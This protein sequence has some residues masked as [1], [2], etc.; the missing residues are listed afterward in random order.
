[1]ISELKTRAWLVSAAPPAKAQFYTGQVDGSWCFHCDW[2]RGIALTHS[3]AARIVQEL[4]HAFIKRAEGYKVVWL[5]DIANFRPTYS[6]IT[7]Q[8]RVRIV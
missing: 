2:R 7:G 5:G 1:M 4:E 6:L 3:E 8:H